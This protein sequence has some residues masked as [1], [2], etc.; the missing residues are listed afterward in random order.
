MRKTEVLSIKTTPEI[1]VA[2]KA[3]GEREHRSMANA[4]ETLVM[5]YFARNG[6]PFPPTAVAVGD[7][8]KSVEE[9]GSQ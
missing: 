8:Q 7:V 9:K 5:D 4:L 2:L 1:K 6:L 3:I